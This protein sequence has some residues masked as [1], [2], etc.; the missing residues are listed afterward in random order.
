MVGGGGGGGGTGAGCS[1]VGGGGG[2]GGDEEEMR[3]NWWGLSRR[4]EEEEEQ[5][6]NRP[7]R[8]QQ[9]H[10]Q[11][12]GHSRAVHLAG[13]NVRVIDVVFPKTIR[14]FRRCRCYLDDVMPD[15]SEHGA[16]V[17]GPCSRQP[18]GDA[19]LEP[20]RQGNSPHLAV[21]AL[22]GPHTRVEAGLLW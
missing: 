15:E 8:D 12:R 22:P 16:W 13:K 10:R 6:G 19:F 11:Q 17:L 4:N 18:R 21:V 20:L 5:E 3:R 1:M 7:A 9:R 2:G 14:P